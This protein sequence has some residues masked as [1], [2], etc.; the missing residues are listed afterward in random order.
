MKLLREEEDQVWEVHECLKKKKKSS[1]PLLFG[2]ISA[3]SI[4]K[5]CAAFPVGTN[6]L[7]STFIHQVYIIVWYWDTSNGILSWVIGLR[8]PS[9]NGALVVK[10]AASLWKQ[11]N[12][13]TIAQ[14]SCR[15]WHFGV[16][17]DP[18]P[19]QCGGKHPLF[20]AWYQSFY[21]FTKKLQPR[22]DLPKLVTPYVHVA[23]HQ[24]ELWVYMWCHYCCDGEN[25]L[26]SPNKTRRT[27][28]EHL[29]VTR[30]A[31]ENTLK[32]NYPLNLVVITMVAFIITAQLCT[33]V[34]LKY[35]VINIYHRSCNYEVNDCKIRS[36][37]LVVAL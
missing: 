25:K 4:A 11:W 8:W 32:Y 26:H 2:E 37:L 15:K 20:K 24:S 17:T 16:F 3:V 12:K 5:N 7:L 10:K 22:L 36:S 35:W 19:T 34:F 9:S 18:R 31:W 13:I 27:I 29:I 30:S 23:T 14:D 1:I 33:T 28:T 21:P 6:F